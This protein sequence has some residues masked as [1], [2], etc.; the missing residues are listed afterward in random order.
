MKRIL[1][2]LLLAASLL[3]SMTLRAGDLAF[4]S[5][6]GD[7]MVL[8]QNTRA[9]IWGKASPRASVS[10]SA[11]WLAAPAEA[12]A[13]ADG[14]WEVMLQTPAATFDPQTIR[15]TS[16]SESVEASNIL[17]G[18]V[19]LCAGQSNMEM[20]LGGGMTV[21]GA[22]EE[23]VFSSQHKGVRYMMVQR[24]KAT[25]PQYD[26]E[27][28]W[29]VCNPKNSPS[30][31]AVA[32]FFATRLSK[33]LEVPVGIINT[34]WGGSVIE[35]WMGEELLK[36]SPD[37]DLSK[38]SD[39]DFKD[40][41][42]PMIMY[43]AM[44]RPASKYTVNGILWFQ[45]ES[46]ISIAYDVY[47]ERLTKMAAEWR[48]DIGRGDIPFLIVELQPYDYYDGTTYGLQD[49]HGPLVREQ[50]FQASRAIP[51]AGIVG[52]NDL[53]YEYERTQVHASQ[54]RQIGERLCY[55][56]LSLAYGI[57]SIPAFNPCF[58]SARLENGKVVVSFD[59]VRGFRGMTEKI[60]G[61]ELAG[62]GG[63]FHPADAELRGNT[64]V[65]STRAV[66]EPVEVR[67][68]FKDF[69]V[70]NLKSASGLPVIPFRAI[71]PVEA[72]KGQ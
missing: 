26:A 72:E 56:A 41:Y 58:K 21:E 9:R 57:T 13:D 30:F 44:F 54:K 31:S 16:G 46:N 52:T 12:R 69:E 51:N 20:T 62:R 48:S 29:L 68:C 49:E 65:L 33:A 36:G 24:A 6:L 59:N 61:F 47:G 4:S 37:I 22:M 19:W 60:V 43:N 67:Y 34:S 71:I 40:T 70:G 3:L 5:L 64:V 63:H 53:A 25:V 39:P 42:K 35:A 10:V 7:N 28:E 66:P 27:G 38:A 23:I 18:E 8:Q 45:G 11:S 50:Q 17:I 15:A 32:Y 55:Q 14:H 2:S 1:K